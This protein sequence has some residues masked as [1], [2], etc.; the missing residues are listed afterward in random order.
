MRV[1]R[2]KRCTVVL[3]NWSLL[4]PEASV[5]KRCWLTVKRESKPERGIVV[6][7]KGL[8]TRR[9]LDTRGRMMDDGFRNRSS[10]KVDCVFVV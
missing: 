10:S 9:A 2:S 3:M 1:R 8:E 5:E 4:V 6:G 7:W